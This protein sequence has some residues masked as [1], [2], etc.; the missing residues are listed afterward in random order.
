MLS[1]PLLAALVTS[2]WSAELEVRVGP[3]PGAI[4]GLAFPNA[5]K[6]TKLQRTADSSWMGR[7]DVPTLR[8]ADDW[9]LSEEELTA[10]AAEEIAATGVQVPRGASLSFFLQRL[11]I[12]TSP[13]A[14]WLE[15]DVTW[16]VQSWQGASLGARK[17]LR[18]EGTGV[19]AADV[20]ALWRQTVRELVGAPAF[21]DRVGAAPTL[22]GDGVDALTL[23]RCGEHVTSATDAVRAAV[24]VR[25][26]RNT[27]AGV[28][29]SP[30]GF[31]VTAAHVLSQDAEVTWHDGTT[32]PA[33]AVRVVRDRD[34]A[35]LRVDAPAG[36]CVAP[37]E[38][39]AALGEDVY[40]V[41]SP[42]G[43]ALGFSMSRGIVSSVREVEGLHL[44]QTD[45]AIS[46]GSS[47]GPLLD[48]K[49]GWLGVL[50]FK[51]VGGGVEGLGFAVA[52]ADALDALGVTFAD[53]TAAALLPAAP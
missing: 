32:S 22:L 9:A 23:R 18:V 38:A 8:R 44:V 49:G 26:G 15:M 16:S 6:V 2:A 48:A 25:S 46:P 33:R 35:L 27:G 51:I 4:I 50:S 5:E 19:A 17:E 1:L 13:G 28:M 41:G 30:D 29:V 34:A 37:R 45:A 7:S 21:A 10:I 42:G 14:S 36:G 39:A 24:I 31:I 3:T 40:A 53:A 52:A 43:S 11:E 12:M 20:L 47:G